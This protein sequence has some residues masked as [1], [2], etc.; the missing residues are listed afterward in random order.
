[1]FVKTLSVKKSIKI[2]SKEAGKASC[3]H[4]AFFV[5]AFLEDAPH[6][7]K[8]EYMVDLFR[9]IPEVVIEQTLR[10][11]RNNLEKIDL[12][13]GHTIRKHVDIQLE[14]LKTRLTM[15]DIKYATSFY[16]FSVAKKAIINLLKQS[17]EEQLITWL[18][19]VGDDVL[20]LQNDLETKL[21]Y[22]YRKRDMALCENLSKIRLVLEKSN[23][24]DWG[25]R[26]VTCFPTF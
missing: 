3:Y 22:G 17:Y 23:E 16:D 8:G 10:N 5:S 14:V 9:D 15:S 13:E 24:R 12:Y 6:L 26:I 11:I 25:F 18:M 20:V 1:M 7:E 19:S 4:D 2:A 21:G